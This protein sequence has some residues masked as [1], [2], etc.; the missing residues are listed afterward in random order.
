MMRRMHKAKADNLPE[1]KIWGSG[2]PK[3]EF[4]YVDDLSRAIE[5]LDFDVDHEIL[6]V[7]SG[8]EVR[9]MSLLKCLKT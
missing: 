3:R 4:L 6:N 9:I 5:L 8:E 2:E 1:F 7:G